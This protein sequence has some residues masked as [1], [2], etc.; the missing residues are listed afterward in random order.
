MGSDGMTVKSRSLAAIQKSFIIQVTIVKKACTAE[1]V[2]ISVPLS[3]IGC[4]ELVLRRN[5]A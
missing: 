3:N 2:Y 4:M 5:K 1:A